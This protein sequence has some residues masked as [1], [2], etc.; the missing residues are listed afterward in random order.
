MCGIVVCI[1]TVKA[2]YFIRLRF[3]FHY[4]Q[5]RCPVVFS[6][7]PQLSASS[8]HN[9]RSAKSTIWWRR[10]LLKRYRCC[11]PAGHRGYPCDRL[12]IFLILFL[13]RDVSRGQQCR[14]W[15]QEYEISTIS[16]LGHKSHAVSLED[17]VR[18]AVGAGGF[19]IR[20]FLFNSFQFFMFFFYLSFTPL[21][22]KRLI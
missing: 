15:W 12:F 18:A 5:P 16:L 22:Q 9:I 7:F 1:L 19:R 20:T 21:T 13:S 2:S 14:M 8:R 17:H 3:V 6:V 10:Q 4:N 11:G